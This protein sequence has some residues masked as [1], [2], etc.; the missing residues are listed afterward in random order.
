MGFINPIKKNINNDNNQPQTIKTV[1][2]TM[3]KKR[4][5]K[6]HTTKF[7]VDHILAVRLKTACKQ[8]N[9]YRNEQHLPAMTQT[10][11][12]TKLLETGLSRMELIDYSLPYKD[13][14]QYMQTKLLESEYQSSIAGPYGI[15][16]RMNLSER[17]V[18]YFIVHS[19]LLH[20]ERG[21]N[22]EEII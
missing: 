14:K 16:V 19:I 20:I 18:V 13:T 6:K 10:E 4:S 9:R 21:G 2:N 7:P 3:R 22:I 12:N 8:L 11:F 1:S 17:K 5:D 15:A